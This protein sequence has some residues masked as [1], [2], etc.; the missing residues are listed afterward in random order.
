[1][2][3]KPAVM[4]RRKFLRNGTIAGLTLPAMLSARSEEN[5]D[6]SV[7]ATGIHIADNEL[8]EITIDELQQKMQSGEWSAKSIA[9]WYLK[10]IDE[11]DKNGPALNSV[12]EVN[13]DAIAIAE[14]M[15]E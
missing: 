13:P 5:S 9:R 8:N 15:D 6:T 7:S 1:M 10:R 4:N 14:A 3:I 12:I 11:I 2:F